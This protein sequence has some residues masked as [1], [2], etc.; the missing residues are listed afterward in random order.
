MLSWWSLS[1]IE[2]MQVKKLKIYVVINLFTDVVINLFTDV[3]IDMETIQTEN[4]YFTKDILVMGD[5]RKE[6]ISGT[7]NSTFICYLLLMGT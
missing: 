6:T 4:I 7:K 3:E 1:E 2:A 5:R